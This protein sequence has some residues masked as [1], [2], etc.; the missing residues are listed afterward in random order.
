MD[1]LVVPIAENNVTK[2]RRCLFIQ[3]DTLFV[4]KAHMEQRSTAPAYADVDVPSTAIALTDMNVSN[5]AA[6]GTQRGQLALKY[7]FTFHANPIKVIYAFSAGVTPRL[8]IAIMYA[9][10][11]VS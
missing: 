4:V 2:R 9:A 7:Q 1:H 8:A 11:G 3:P 5:C 10:P 6:W